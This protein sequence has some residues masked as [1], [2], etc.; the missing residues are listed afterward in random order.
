[1][2]NKYIIYMYIIT[3]HIYNG[4]LLSYKIN[5]TKLFPVT[6]DELE[7]IMLSKVSQTEKDRY[8]TMSLIHEI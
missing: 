6:W 7:M 1:M 3:L 2:N 4:I 8:H 5:K